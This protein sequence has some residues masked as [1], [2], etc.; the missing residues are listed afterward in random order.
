M[1]VPATPA[2]LLT[3]ASQEAILQYSRNCYTQQSMMFNIR[4]Q[5][6]AIDLAYIRENDLTKANQRARIAN[7]YGDADKYQNITV[8][9]VM[10]QVEAAVVYQSS[11][12]LTGHPIFGV[13]SGAKNADEALQLETVIE[14]QSVRGKWVAELMKVF[15]D[16]F[17]YNLSAMEVDWCTDTVAALETDLKFSTT[18]AKPREISWQGNRLKHLNLYNTIF[19]PRVLPTEIPI[20]GDYAGYTEI[21]T[22]IRLKE[23]IASL[24]A[25]IIDNIIPAFNSGLGSAGLGTANSVESF[26]IPQL[27]PN[28][29]VDANIQKFTTNWLT[30]AG[31]AGVDSKIAYK[32]VYQWTV[33]YARIL[34][35]DFS[36]R[37][38]AKNTPQI[39]KFIII[40]HQVIIY[41]ERMTNAHN[42]IPILFSQPNEDGLGLQ[43]KSLAANVQPMQDVTSAMWNSIIAARRRAIS[44][45]T[46]YDPSRVSEAQINN[47]NPS[48]K[49]P[50][51]PS[52]YGKPVGESVYAFPF[53]DDQ[54]GIIL[55]EVGTVL[56]M[57]DMIT[58]QNKVRQGQFV[59]GNKTRREFDT[60]MANANGRDQTTSLLLEAQ[61][62]TPLKEM[63]K[64]NILQYQGATSIY[65]RELQKDIPIEPEKLRKAVLEF[66]ISDGLTP[67]DKLINTETMQVAMQV[68]G[69]TP[70]IGAAYNIAPM[71]SYLMKMEGAKE[72]SNF[73][74][75]PEQI[76]YEQ[77]LNSWQG[78]VATVSEALKGKTP[79]E[80]GEILKQ[81]PPQ[82]TPE[83]FGY[84]PKPVAPKQPP[85]SMQEAQQ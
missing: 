74:K 51:R 35:S 2:T 6:R 47:P 76:A 41:A 54:T 57:A 34:P 48:A 52:A 44:D 19:D 1:T 78:M 80:I 12:F 72:I 65:N 84:Q 11:V 66:K 69:S 18:Q 73:E 46:L 17:K 32:D 25:K 8:P 75:S 70:Q 82:P 13:V 26:Y 21:V 40:N 15:R 36:L 22:R 55:Q 68:I 81:L 33:L 64:I 61:L 10:P 9:V 56:G 37:V 29:L 62:F 83:Q 14:D 3:R 67:S 43:T 31:I 45:R 63:L 38:P 49:I 53:R 16:G 79:I 59:K 71:F 77:A 4:E 27:N 39:W 30:W 50:V 23:L 85:Q 20:K 28:A 7:R 58:G 24:P 5:L 60:V 42:M